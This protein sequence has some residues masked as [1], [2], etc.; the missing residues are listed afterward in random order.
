MESNIASQIAQKSR[1]YTL[2]LYFDNDLHFQRQR[3][4]IFLDLRI[5]RKW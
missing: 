4:G 5:S 3:F 2:F 1:F